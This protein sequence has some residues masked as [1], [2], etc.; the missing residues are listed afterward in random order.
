MRWLVC[1][2]RDFGN[3]GP[4]GP[5][6]SFIITKLEELA[7]K[8]CPNY[9]SEE[10]QLPEGVEIIAGKARGV[11]TVAVDWAVV[12]WLP[13]KEFPAQWDKY[14]K[15]AGFIRNKQ[16]LDE[17]KPDLV[18]AFPGGIGTKM[19]VNLSKKAGVEVIEYIY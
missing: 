13:F 19:M 2:G 11:D 14:G 7:S 3:D 16:M 5:Q 9:P 18:I 1:S 4:N 8:Y 15:S 17:G 12:N 6:F 10:V